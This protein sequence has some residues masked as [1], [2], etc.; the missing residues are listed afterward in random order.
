MD[1]YLVISSDCHAGLPPERYRD[2]VDPRYREAFDQALPVQVR[3]TR[4]AEK[5]FP[6][7]EVNAEWRKGNEKALSGA[8]DHDERIKVLD[9]DGI[10]GEIIFPDGVTEM[11]APP[12]GG[13]FSMPTEGVVPELQ[14]AGC[15][16]HN[17]WMAELVQMAP[18]RRV[19]LAC[20]PVFWD[21]EEAVKEIR[22]ARDNGLRGLVLPVMWGKQPPYHHPRYDPVWAVCQDLDMV[23]HFHSGPAPAEEYFGTALGTPDAPSLTGA[24]GIYVSE[25][26]LWCV[27][28]ITFMIWG[29]VFERYPGLKVAVTEGTSIWV[30]E[31][32]MLLDQ[33][34]AQTHYNQKLGD[35]Q[36][37]L[38]QTPS[39]YFR[40]NVRLGASCMP[41]REAEK[42]YETGVAQIMWGSDYPHPE[43]S[44]PFTREQMLETFRGLPDDEIAA[45]LGG[46]A[47]SF[48]GFDV[49]KLAPLVSRIGPEKRLFRAD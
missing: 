21:V 2:Y 40:R 46:N 37:H 10:A 27:R 3:M 16:A 14:W 4:E 19:G 18:E 38:S 47:A 24:M 28:P 13:G 29:G 34:Y 45:M 6:V 35:F 42:R 33:R 49:E 12:F 17:R 15:R 39:E 8:W 30:P 9:G 48:Y 32:L 22:W 7:A 1:R 11:N 23:V 20:V 44:W 5:R 26:C 36:S 41:R 25:V 43:G 31:Y